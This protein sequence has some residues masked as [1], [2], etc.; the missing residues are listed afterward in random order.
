MQINRF[1]TNICKLEVIRTP[2]I[3]Q[4]F[5]TAKFNLEYE[6]FKHQ[7][8]LFGMIALRIENPEREKIKFSNKS[9]GHLL[10]LRI[11]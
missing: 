11:I 6:S 5:T 8:H 7:Y 4:N 9:A 2:N 3:A 10:L 1:F